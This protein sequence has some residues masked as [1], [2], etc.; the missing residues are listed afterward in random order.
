MSLDPPDRM[1]V[2]EPPHSDRDAQA[3]A[4]DEESEP[5]APTDLMVVSRARRSNAG[6]RMSTL[7]AKS[8]EE[9]EWGEEWEEAPNEEEFLGDEANDQDDFN[10]DSSSS[11]EGDDEGADDDAGEKELRKAERQERIKKRKPATNPFTARLAAA[12][13]KRVKLD[14]PT[15]DTQPGPAPRPKKKSERASWIP[16]PEEGPTRTSS[17]KQTVANKEHT[18]AK[19]KEK[20]RRRDDTLAMMKAAEARKAKDEPKAM[21]Q[22]ERLAEAARVERVNS[23]SLHRWEVAEEQRAA[24]RQAQIDALK[25]RQIEGPFVRWYS[26]P[27]IR[28]DNQVKYTGKGCPTVAELEAKYNKDP[29]PV[30]RPA[31]HESDTVVVSSFSQSEQPVQK[32]DAPSQS[33]VSQNFPQYSASQTSPT[34]PQQPSERHVGTA[35]PGSV[36]FVPPQNPDSFLSGIEQYTTDQQKAALQ[37]QSSHT[38]PQ[39]QPSVRPQPAS[40]PDQTPQYTHPQ[41]D[42]LPPNPFS[43]PPL[44][45]PHPSLSDPALHTALD[46]ASLLQQ[47]K[48]PPPAPL[49]PRKRHIV[50][51]EREVITMHSFPHLDPATSTTQPSSRARTSTSLSKEKDRAAL[52]QLC[53]ALFAWTHADAA[54]FVAQ[55]LNPPKTKR[56]LKAEIMGVKK[57]RCAIT[58]Q[59][60]RYRDPGTGIAYRD[61]KAFAVLRG[62]VEGGFVWSGALGCYV[63]G[64]AKGQGQGG[65]G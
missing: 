41:I 58:N 9:E 11:E 60:A 26:G 22:A 24:E 4:S 28:V 43:Q 39:P 62:I 5:E 45:H 36:M 49:P 15:S 33:T 35:Y 42:Q 51:L 21:S 48:R 46:P 44:S 1:D 56:E 63:G 12:A 32:A 47:F 37:D 34:S 16:T 64:R 55:S 40:T 14:V 20:D 54:S 13:R 17:R 8:A 53:I 30:S 3:S 2:D 52:I 7:L 50:K 25:N 27:T 38:T 29:P 10:L 31:A 65:A 19:L 18:L 23:K 59:V 6:N 57:E 61:R